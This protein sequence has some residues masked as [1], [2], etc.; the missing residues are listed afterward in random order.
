[1]FV[2]KDFEKDVLSSFVDLKS[3]FCST[4]YL[5]D[6]VKGS[7]ISFKDLEKIGL[8]DY[9]TGDWIDDL[10]E[11]NY[12]FD[13]RKVVSNCF[14]YS[15]WRQGEELIIEELNKVRNII[16]Q[17]KSSI[18][19][20]KIEKAKEIL[21]KN[22]PHLKRKL[23]G[24]ISIHQWNELMEIDSFRGAKFV[25]DNDNKFGELSR[26]WMGINWFV[27]NRLPLNKHTRSCF[28]YCQNSIGFAFGNTV[29]GEVNYHPEKN[30]NFVSICLKM[31][32]KT[33]N[34]ADIVKIL[35]ADTF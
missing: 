7:F 25:T 22:N 10:D 17:D 35:C 8:T 9:Y 11:L 30:S 20:E 13:E 34:S 33:I 15:L 12:N 24:V 26:I 21:N 29:K 4:V 28:I 6:K 32:I 31:G 14:A 16:P 18:T 27:D 1:M 2:M 5:K 3:K 23:F 19:I